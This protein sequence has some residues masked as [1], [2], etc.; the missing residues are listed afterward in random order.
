MKITKLS[1]FD[2]KDIKIKNTEAPPQFP[3]NLMDTY[4]RCI[5]I[6]HSGSGKT[7]AIL[8]LIQYLQPYLND[9]YTISPTIHNDPKQSEVLSSFN[10]SVVFDEPS[11]EVLAEIIK[12]IKL[13]NEEYYDYRDILELFKKFKKLKYD[14]DKLMP[15]ELL[16]LYEINFNPKAH[17]GYSERKLSNLIFLDDL[18]G[19]NDILRGRI[20]PAFIVKCRHMM[21]SSIINLQCLKGMAPTIRRN[22]SLWLIFKSHDENQL[23]DIF[24]E[25]SGMFN[26]NYDK[27][28]KAYEYATKEKYNFLYIDMN[29]FKTGIRKNFNEI[30]TDL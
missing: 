21:C 4:F 17:P 20:L 18:Q 5:C 15:N 25:V 28:L 12:S 24:Q 8:N 23:K 19:I 1:N 6:G 22:C 14:P 9:I 7:M 16:R 10:N 11:E 30:I 2:I 26:G 29:N 27:F 13:K 3:Q